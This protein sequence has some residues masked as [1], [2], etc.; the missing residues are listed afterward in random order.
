MA[1]AARVI[2][3]LAVVATAVLGLAAAAVPATSR[4]Y[5]V[6]VD[7]R[8]FSYTLSRKSVPA[9]STVR[10]VVRNRGAQS[11]DF[12]VKRKRT[13][14]LRPGQAQT[15]TV[16]FPKKGRFAFLC[17]VSGHARLGM[18]GQFGVAVKPVETQPPP[19]PPVNTSDLV[20]LTPVGTFDR[21]VL[22]TAPTGDP[23]R[24][25]VVEQTG[26]VRLVRDGEVSPTPFLDNCPRA[27]FR[28][29]RA[30]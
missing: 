21:P 24:A 28:T 22:V 23:D 17:T 26:T 14:V 13:R 2:A 15:I 16:A 6:R 25:Y 11:H 27:R 3:L 1:R 12:S 10:F 19:K 18:T 7:A 4:T 9:G 5:T 30:R 20:T 8:D 29:A